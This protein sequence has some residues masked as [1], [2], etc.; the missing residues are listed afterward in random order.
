M[1]AS[2]AMREQTMEEIL[3]SIH[4]MIV[5]GDDASS[6]RRGRG[7]GAA[8]PVLRPVTSIEDVEGAFGN[9]EARPAADAGGGVFAGAPAWDDTAADDLDSQ[10]FVEGVRGSRRPPAMRETLASGD[11]EAVVGDAFS[12]LSRLVVARNPR[13]LEDLM[14]ETLRPML[15]DWIDANL[16]GIA[17][18]LV[19]QEIDRISG[20]HR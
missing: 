15:R 18:R 8:A 17:E 1:S 16:P 4:R 5:D 2:G 7:H 12:A 6:R 14:V 13:T 19:Q 10:R 3:A 9:G 20:P 11:T